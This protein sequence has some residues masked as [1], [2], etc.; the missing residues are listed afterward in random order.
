MET[1]FFII[2]SFAYLFFSKYLD[3]KNK[4]IEIENQIKIQELSNQKY[5]KLLE[6]LNENLQ[7][8]KN[9]FLIKT[10]KD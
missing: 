5:Q 9:D 2:I 4:K 7:A 1:M 3:F 8:I 10:K 6:M